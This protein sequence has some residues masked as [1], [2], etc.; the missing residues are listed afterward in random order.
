V[1]SRDE[2]FDLEKFIVRAH[3]LS[4]VIKRTYVRF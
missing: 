3:G 2:A 1:T 4:R